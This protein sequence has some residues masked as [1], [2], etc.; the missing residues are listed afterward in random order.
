[1]KDNDKIKY[2][3]NKEIFMI[4]DIEF[5][6]NVI[7]VKSDTNKILAYLSYHS[8]FRLGNLANTC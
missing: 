5:Q 8:Y 7:I 3:K 6:S 2:L 1:M 4:I